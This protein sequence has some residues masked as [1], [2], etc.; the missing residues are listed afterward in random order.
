[1]KLRFGMFRER[2]HSIFS[3]FAMVEAVVAGSGSLKRFLK[4][5]RGT[6]KH[7]DK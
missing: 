2:Y 7:N 4:K 3:N 1:L 5:T 6:E